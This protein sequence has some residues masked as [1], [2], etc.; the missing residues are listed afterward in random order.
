MRLPQLI[1]ASIFFAVAAAEVDAGLESTALAPLIKRANAY[2]SVG[3]FGDAAR[4]YS[5]AI[6]TVLLHSLR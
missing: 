6:G 3:Q 2:L 4:T 1:I 5:E